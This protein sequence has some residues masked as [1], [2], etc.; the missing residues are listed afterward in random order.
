MI[1]WITPYNSKE[2]TSLREQHLNEQPY[3]VKCHTTLRLQVDHIVPH[4]NRVEWF[5]N[6]DNLQTLCI[7]HHAEKTNQLRF[8]KDFPNYDIA[9]DIKL[10]QSR[11]IMLQQVNFLKQQASQFIKYANR[12][13]F[14]I[15]ENSLSFKMV[16][17]LVTLLCEFFKRERFVSLNITI[18]GNEFEQ[19]I[20]QF[21]ADVLTKV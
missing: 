15:V 21:F 8:L 17:N 12:Y 11:G 20:R 4:N 7:S 16:E 19:S 6:P 9:I 5:L 3:C 14:N 1:N 2:W 13:E 10:N 18:K